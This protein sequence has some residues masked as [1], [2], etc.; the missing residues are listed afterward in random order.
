MQGLKQDEAAT[1]AERDA[2]FQ[3]DSR[4]CPNRAR[5]AAMAARVSADG[6]FSYQLA[7]VVDN[8]DMRLT[9]KGR[10]LGLV[11]DVRWEAF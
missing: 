4:R 2:L 7:V 6:L 9:E 1:L 10:E 3:S 11:D 5:M 8:A